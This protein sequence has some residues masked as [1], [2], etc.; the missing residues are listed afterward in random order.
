MN[1]TVA[2]CVASILEVDPS[3]VPLPPVE[4]PEPWTVWRN[5]LAVRGLGLVPIAQPARFSWPGPWVAL[6][7]AA[8]GDELRA[9]VAFGS[10]P[11]IAW[12]PLP[13]QAFEQV[14]EGWL[15]AP[16]DVALAR[17][18]RGAPGP[19]GVVDALFTA[20]QAEAELRGVP[21]VHADA[22][23]G[24]A[25]DRYHAG[26][27]TFSNPHARGH[28]L[29]LIERET[30]DAMRDVFPGYRAEDARRNIVTTEIALNDLVGWRFRVG[31]V[32]CIGQRLCEP[33]AHLDRVAV[34][35]ALRHLVHRGGLRADVI[36]SG[37]IA[38]GD[39]IEPLS[40]AA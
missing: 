16:A 34:R 40:P 19:R 7:P 31:E 28:D 6:V 30:I 20:P 1:R 9:V 10:P 29:T 12:A 33:C 27:G 37:R 21:E 14:R 32:E 23:R 11:G 4:H 17:R 15:I 22:G 35:G 13:T 24:L 2:A 38:V 26:A 5:W 18:E 8:D 3:A 25:G 36:S 39:A